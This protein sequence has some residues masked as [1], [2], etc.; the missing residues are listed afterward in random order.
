VAQGR[1]KKPSES[2]N[3]TQESREIKNAKELA[4]YSRKT[5]TTRERS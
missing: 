1:K 4:G 2:H 5:P 3:G